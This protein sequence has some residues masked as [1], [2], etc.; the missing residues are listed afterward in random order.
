MCDG[1][2][3]REEFEELRGEVEA[4]REEDREL[5]D[6][7]AKK[8][9]RIDEVEEENEELQERVEEAEAEAEKARTV[10]REIAASVAEIETETTADGG[11]EQGPQSASSPLDFFLNCQQ[12]HVNQS[13]SKNRARAVEIV[14]RREE[15]GRKDSSSEAWYISRENVETALT[16]ILG[17]RPHRETQRRVWKFIGDMGGPDA[18]ETTLQGNSTPWEGTLGKKKNKEVYKVGP[19][20]HERFSESRYVGMNL[21]ADGKPGTARDALHGGVTPVVTG[22]RS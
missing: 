5:R 2:V 20:A 11:E 21:L 14:R 16:A 15:F 6:E 9:D 22:V 1:C 8:D 17:E 3:G 7:L 19:E 4:L 18:E 13:L 12:F 10:A